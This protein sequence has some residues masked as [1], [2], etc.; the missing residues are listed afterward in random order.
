MPRRGCSEGSTLLRETRPAPAIDE[1]P[2]ELLKTHKGPH[3]D[4]GDDEEELVVVMDELPVDI[5]AMPAAA[6]ETP[7]R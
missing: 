2:G 7:N 4:S 5:P 1:S 3:K 6:M